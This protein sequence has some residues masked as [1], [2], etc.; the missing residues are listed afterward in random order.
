MPKQPTYLLLMQHI[1]GMFT[2]KP[3]IK[4]F[5]RNTSRGYKIAFIEMELSSTLGVGNETSM[6]TCEEERKV[7]IVKDTPIMLS[8]LRGHS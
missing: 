2:M 5:V 4:D 8:P 3:Y 1:L 6:A 7:Y